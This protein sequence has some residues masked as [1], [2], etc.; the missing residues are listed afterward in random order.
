M[1]EPPTWFKDARDIRP[2]VAYVVALLCLLALPWLGLECLFGWCVVQ[3]DDWWQYAFGLAV[4]VLLF[5][6]YPLRLL[7]RWRGVEA[8]DPD[9]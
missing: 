5:S 2:L 1:Y 7:D 4:P 8:P 3:S 6:G 9:D